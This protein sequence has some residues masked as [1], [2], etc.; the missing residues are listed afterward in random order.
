MPC[1]RVGA[2]WI[3]SR[4]RRGKAPLC[5]VCRTRPATQLCD[6]PPPPGARRVTCDAALCTRCS[7]HVPAA[8]VLLP[9]HVE[10]AA[11]VKPERDDRDF[12]P[13]CAAASHVA[14]QLELPRVP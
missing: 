6:G 7:A 3:C 12:C 2:Y 10:R 1:E 4:G 14:G 8:V 9:S 13:R 11:G 5:S